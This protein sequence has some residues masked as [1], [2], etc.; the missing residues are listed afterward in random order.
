MTEKRTYR[1]KKRAESREETRA[2]IV[3][4]TMRLH[5]EIGPRA[6]TI[7]AIAERAGVQRLTVYRHFPDETAVFQAC[8]SHWLSLNPPPDPRD[9]AGIDDG[10]AAVRSALAA[11]YDYYRRTERMWTVSVREAPEVPA[12]HGPM[13]EIARYLRETGEDLLRRFSVPEQRRS[14]LAATVHHLISFTTW[15]SLKEQGLSDAETVDLACLWTRAAS[16]SDP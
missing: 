5:E 8:T 16:A 2:R 13:S 12:L 9:W 10:L 4:A 3:D 15:M 7:S 14:R 1:L 6:T 11:F